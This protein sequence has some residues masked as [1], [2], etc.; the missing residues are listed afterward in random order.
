VV[1]FDLDLT[2]IDTTP[3]F[4]RVLEVLGEELGVRLPVPD[5]V[6]RLG[7]PLDHLLRPHLAEEAVGPAVD[8]FRVLYPDHAIT[9]VPLL[10]GAADAV[11]AVRA[12]G[13][14]VVVVTGKFTPNA[15]LHVEHLGLHV[16]ALVGEVWG[17]GKG[18]ALRR[19]GASM[20]V[21]DHVHDVEG[22]RAAGALSVSVATGGSSRAELEAAGTDVL[23]EDLAAFPDWLDRHLAGARGS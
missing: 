14:R 13:G 11:A 18:A 3:G 15:R 2:L 23:L 10:P 16:D 19:E 9:T 6:A 1:G 17:S 20:Y 4:A 8:R 22:A 7:P 5:M 21:G 12:H